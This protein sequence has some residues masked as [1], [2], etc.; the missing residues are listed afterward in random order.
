VQRSTV[1]ATPAQHLP[2]LT[3]LGFGQLA[4]PLATAGL[5]I[6]VFVTAF[7]ARDIHISI[8][9]VGIILLLARITDFIVD[10]LIGYLSDRTT[11]GIGR[12]RTWVFLGIP[13]FALGVYM[14]FLPPAVLMQQSEFARE[15]YLLIWVAVYYLGWTMI[16]IPYGAWGAELSDDYNERSRITGV[17]EIFTLVGLALAGSIPVLLGSAH[18]EV[19][20]AGGRAAGNLWQVMTVL[21][22]SIL[23]LTPVGAAILYF[24][25]PEPPVKEMEHIPVWRAVK[26]AA[27]NWPFI[28]LFTSIIGIRMGSRGAEG[29]LLFYLVDAAGLAESQA[30]QSLLALLVASIFFAPFWIWAG[31]AWTK[32][33]ALSIAM[34]AGIVV[35]AV[36]PALRGMGFWP[37]ILAF[38]ALGSAFSAPFTLGQSMAADVVDLDSLR[39]RQPRAGLLISFFG[40]AIKGGDML[41]VF[42]A[43][44]LAGTFGY[45]PS[46]PVKTHHAVQVLSAVYVLFPILFWIPSI[47]LI[48]N[49]PIT[50]AIQHRIRELIEKRVKLEHSGKLRKSART[51]APAPENHM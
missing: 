38:A 44:W 19:A 31:K 29:L 30:R 48:W 23:V 24:T 35:F 18:A 40:I 16:T 41:G 14:L 37:N 46:D 49:F 13:I 5:P 22:I 43:L 6:A 28:R 51:T 20:V 12:R 36:L 45:T 15:V 27:T 4:V 39:T 47:A 17:R 1:E 33:K 21:G 34:M 10:P 42:L 25:T 8:A 26:A 50:P 11:W 32:H 3:L 2:W 9:D 7:Y